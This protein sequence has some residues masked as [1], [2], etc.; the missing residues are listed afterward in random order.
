MLCM[1]WKRYSVETAMNSTPLRLKR[2]EDCSP[3]ILIPSAPPKSVPYKSEKY[4]KMLN[5]NTSLMKL[6][7]IL[8][9]GT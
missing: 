6:Y 5:M 4:T 2:Q 1:V 9:A 3:L 7:D 8:C